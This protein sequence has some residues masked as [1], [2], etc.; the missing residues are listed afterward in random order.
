VTLDAASLQVVVARLS[1]VAD[2]MG[3]VLRRAASSPNIK[4]RADCSAACFTASGELLAQAEH[5]PVH[6]GSMPAAVRAA[7]DALGDVGAGRQLVSNDPFAGGT[8]LNDVTIVTPV[9]IDGILVAWVANRAHHADLGGMA[10]GS[11]SPDAV[12]IHQEGLRIPPVVLTDEVERLIA[13]ASR[14]P[15]ERRGDL[16]AQ[17]GANVIGAERL[18]AVVRGLGGTGPLEEVLDYGERRMRAALVE[19]PDG[20]YEF[21]DVLDSAG[22]H[23]SQQSPTR[24]NLTLTLEGDTACFD[25]TG[26]DAQRRGNV[27]AVQAVT[28]S[29]V[30]FAIR[31][32]TDPTIPANGGA[33]RPVRVI[34]PAG[35]VVAALPPVAVGAGNVE[36]SQRIADVCL[37]ALARAAPDRVGAAGQ[38][39]MNNVL[40]GGTG[41]TAG[42]W[43]YYETIGGGQGARPWADGMSGVHTAMTN[44][45]DTPVEALERALP[46]RVRRFALRRSS[47]GPGAHRGGDGIE[48]EVEVLT[49]AIASLVTERRIR[50]PWGIAGGRPGATGENWLLPSGDETAAI[51]LADKCTVALHAGDVVRI[52]TPGGGGWGTPPTCFDRYLVVDWSAASTPTSGAD[53]IWIASLGADEA[54]DEPLHLEN[55]RTRHDAMSSLHDH[56]RD[57][58]ARGERVL[59]G[60]DA[61]FGYPAGFASAL[62]PGGDRPWRAVWDQVAA[63]SEDDAANR[64]NRF[65]VAGAIN[66]GIGSGPGPFWGRPV[67]RRVARLAPGKPSFPYAGLAEHRVTE[68]QVV[69]RRP[70]SAWQL[71][72]RGAVGGQTL[73][74]LPWLVALRDAADLEAHVRIWPFETGFTPDPTGGDRAAIVFAEVWP[75]LVAPDRVA[76]IDH[77]VKDARQVAA[78]AERLC[79]LDRDGELAGCFDA[80]DVD[81]ATRSTAMREEGW[82]L[83]LG[84]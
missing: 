42:S 77:D 19:L 40:L 74:L 2:E 38:G 46:V 47:G 48:R 69:G 29:A 26:T 76:G 11:M 17:R 31:A 59:V 14:T 12:D 36:V 65:E 84:R 79:E 4:E 54:L 67:N 9:H 43:V 18:A 75:G 5:I 57:A 50:A 34:A 58:V 83:P 41:G 80:P 23:R 24:I 35:S 60:F 73:T 28:V 61:S 3:A 52:L 13:A 22:P 66:A 16:A 21:D 8:H 7:I 10:P 27:N 20:R 53:S 49:D 25:F 72:G 81:D 15:E 1:G 70:Q 6:L 33:L 37:G 63:L 68:L 45:A 56:L 44:T 62:A 32:A 82:I 51:R 78:L 64:N 71:L 30:A 39:T 55:P